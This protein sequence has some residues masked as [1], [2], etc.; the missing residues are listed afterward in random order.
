[1]SQTLKGQ[2]VLI[3]AGPTREYIDPVRFFTNPS[4]GKMG[5]ALAEAALKKGARV[6]LIS[7]PTLLKP[8]KQCFFVEVVSAREMYEVVL[9]HFDEADMVIKT[10]A[11]ADYRP[12]KTSLKKIKKQNKVLHLKLSP[13]PDILATLGKRKK[14]QF[15]IGF[16]AETDRTVFYARKKLKKKNCDLMIVNRVG[17][18]GIGFGSDF[19]QVAIIPPSGKVCHLGRMSKKRLAL[20]IMNYVL[21]SRA[22]RKTRP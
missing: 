17:R 1:M 5:Y 6:I 2:T 8:P 18:H 9:E 13:N 14:G 4:T 21:S 11:V 20:K 12:Q 15:L 19:N 3:T 16:A 7:G 22:Y 10:A